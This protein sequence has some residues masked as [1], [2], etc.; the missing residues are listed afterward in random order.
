M[1]A[2]VEEGMPSANA[3]R[4]RRSRARHRQGL[5]VLK[6]EAHED[7]LVEALLRIRRLSDEESRRRPLVER[8]VGRLVDDWCRRWLE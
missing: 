5:I 6:V 2:N 7:R 1:A 4:Q 8:E 3:L